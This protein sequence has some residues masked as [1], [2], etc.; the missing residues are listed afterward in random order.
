[1]KIH[2]LGCNGPYPAA[3]GGT[4]GYLVENEGK[5]LLMDC[6]SGTL[7][8]LMGLCDPKALEGILLSHLHYDHMADALVLSYY[9]PGLPV[10][11]PGEEH[12]VKPL[13][14]SAF[15]VRPFPAPGETVSMIGLDISFFPTRHPVPCRAMRMT[16]GGKTFVYTGDTNEC[17]GLDAFAAGADV[18]L[19]DAAFL[20]SE[21]NDRLP[22]LSARRCALLAQK[23]HA[24]R[25]YLTHLPVRHDAD[26]LE[27][28][29]RE[30][31]PDSL[32]VHTGMTI[33]V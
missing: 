25:L 19:A 13:L 9:A 3:F 16:G 11:C 1:M 5:Y 18:L 2:V 27:R 22:H 30:V 32:A 12:A 17:D 4:S 31:F 15:D 20:E 26:T 24:G 23:A 21:W 28:E 6:G 7:S 14:Q 8:R 29:A 10:Y 33:V